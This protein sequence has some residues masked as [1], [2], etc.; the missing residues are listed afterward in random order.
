MS[1][2][3]KR[4]RS[5]KAALPRRPVPAS[6]A[7]DLVY[8]CQATA[9]AWDQQAAYEL[10]VHTATTPRLAL[11]WLRN[12][13]RDI[14]DQLDPP[15][16]QPAHHWLADDEA[17]EHALTQLTQGSPY[18]LTITDDPVSYTLSAQPTPLRPGAD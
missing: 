3:R 13:A 6:T 10:G 18:T 17:H 7:P 16:A 15:V 9:Y 8:Y 5:G 14:T 2:H 12:R 4:S 1:R 11:R